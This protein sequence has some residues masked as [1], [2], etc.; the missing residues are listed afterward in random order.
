MSVLIAIQTPHHG[1][2]ACS[3]ALTAGFDSRSFFIY[4]DAALGVKLVS[5]PHQLVCWFSCFSPQCFLPSL[6]LFC[7]LCSSYL[8]VHHFVVPCFF[9]ETRHDFSFMNLL[10]SL[11]L[12]N[13]FD[14]KFH[15]LLFL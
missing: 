15:L 11:H 12:S 9:F 13:V 6:S 10:N 5:C 4:L 2:H 14:K 7:L 1:L 3:L 8:S